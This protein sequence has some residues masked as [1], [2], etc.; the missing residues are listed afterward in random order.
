MLRLQ[1][2]SQS[3][4]RRPRPVTVCLSHEVDLGVSGSR[5]AGQR[6]GSLYGHELLRGLE[7]IPSEPRRL[8][9]VGPQ[10]IHSL[11]LLHINVTK[12]AATRV[13]VSS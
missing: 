9:V 7:A 5:G 11:H 13:T 4:R 10:I 1:P 8:C 6:R 2:G 3:V 12:T